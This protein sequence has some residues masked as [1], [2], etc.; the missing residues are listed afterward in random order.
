MRAADLPPRRTS[1]S[2]TDVAADGQAL[3]LPVISVLVLAFL[4]SPLAVIVLTSFSDSRYL[5]FPPPGLSLRWYAAF[6]SSREFVEALAVSVRLATLVAGTTILIALPAG[7]S[8]SRFGFRGRSVVEAFLLSPLFFPNIV[9]AIALLIFFSRLRL[10]GTF[11]GLLLAHCVV[12]F[13]YVLRTVAA[14]VT[15]VDRRLEEAAMS[16]GASPSRAFLLVTLPMI[17]P[18]LVTATVF[19]FIISMDEVVVSLFLSGA[20]V[21]TLPVRIYSYIQFTSD[22]TIAAI[23]SVL[24]LIPLA[25]VILFPRALFGGGFGGLGSTK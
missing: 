4:V 1:P 16:L 3:V 5:V 17:R 12:A 8:I 19:A 7:Y 23:S 6:F 20:G 18:S 11:P 9:L 14:G 22:A 15:T 10:V 21:T 13:P 2:G 24:L 25:V